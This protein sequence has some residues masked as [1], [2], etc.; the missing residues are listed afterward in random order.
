MVAPYGSSPRG[1]GTLQDDPADGRVDRFIPAWAGN[2]RPPYFSGLHQP[3]HPRVGGERKTIRNY[4]KS[5]NGSSPR[6]RGTHGLVRVPRYRERFIPAWAGNALDRHRAC[7]CG[8]VHPRVGGERRR[9]APMPHPFAGS[10][11]RGRGTRETAGAYRSGHRF[12]PAWAGNAAHRRPPHADRPVHPRV[13]GEREAV[14]GGG[15]RQT[16]SSPRGRGT[17]VD[18]E[19][20]C[21]VHRF[22]PAWAG[23]AAA[24]CG[25]RQRKPVHPRVGGERGLG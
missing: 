4:S 18:P 15:K 23:N 10:S 12:I 13:G 21:P 19:R 25:R 22:I 8:T 7:R 1:R 14:Q 16:G 20:R 6:G 9:P 3:V 2:A 5:N 11:P 17:P 24:F